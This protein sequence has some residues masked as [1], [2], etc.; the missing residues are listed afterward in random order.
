M[1]TQ[2]E[3]TAGIKDMRLRLA[4]AALAVGLAAGC[5]PDLEVRPQ[6]TNTAQWIQLSH[7]VT[8]A[9]GQASLS[10]QAARAIDAFVHRAEIAYGDRIVIKGGS[11]KSTPMALAAQRAK[12][13]A[14]YLRRHRIP[15]RHSPAVA[16]TVGADQ[17]A[18][19]VGRY[20]VVAPHCPAWSDA[21]AG[22]DLSTQNDRYGPFLGFANAGAMGGTGGNSPFGTAGFMN[23]PLGCVTASALGAQIADPGDLVNGGRLGPGDGEFFSRGMRRYRADKTKET[24]SVK[25]SEQGG[26]AK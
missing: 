22:G 7:K 17:S 15:S 13:V 21:L 26:G 6:P 25:T 18:I 3:K 8:F 1:S 16:V 19:V 11:A 5:A 4:A 12:S 14:A 23:P 9:P 24:R 10:P 20:I 2:Y